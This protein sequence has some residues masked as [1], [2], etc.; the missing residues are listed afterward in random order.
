MV[1]IL[2]QQKKKSV[3][4]FEDVWLM[5]KESVVLLSLKVLEKWITC[6]FKQTE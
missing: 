1:L 3:E 5:R 2:L 4:V 6:W